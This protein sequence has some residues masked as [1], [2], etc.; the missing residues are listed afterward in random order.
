M[1]VKLRNAVLRRDINAR[2]TM[3]SGIFLVKRTE[4]LNN[5]RGDCVPVLAAKQEGPG[6]KEMKRTCC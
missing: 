2:E 6:E 1:S 3:I 5:I 4:C